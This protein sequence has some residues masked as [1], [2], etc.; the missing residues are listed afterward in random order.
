METSFLKI[1]NL[2]G[3]SRLSIRNPLVLWSHRELRSEKVMFKLS[4]ETS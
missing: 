3:K 1:E 4:V 2:G